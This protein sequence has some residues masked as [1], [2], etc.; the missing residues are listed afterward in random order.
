MVRDHPREEEQ[1]KG[2]LARYRDKNWSLRDTIPF[3]VMESRAV[4]SAL[5]FDRPFLQY[6]RFTV[7]GL[8]P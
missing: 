3:A 8:M 7:L 5:T 1:A 4:H 6:G 2:I